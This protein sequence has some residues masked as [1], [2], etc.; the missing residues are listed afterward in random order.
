MAESGRGSW[1]EKF[2]K[3]QNTEPFG[4]E[5]CPRYT[6]EVDQCAALE[7]RDISSA[8]E[9]GLCLA[10]LKH[11][12]DE[13]VEKIAKGNPSLYTQED[14]TEDIDFDK[15]LTRMQRVDLERWDIR[16][17]LACMGT[18]VHRAV[19]LKLIRRGIIAEA[20][21][22]GSCKH[23]SQY[24]PRMCSLPRYVDPDSGGLIMNALHGEIRKLGDDP[25]PGYEDRQPRKDDCQDAEILRDT[26]SLNSGDAN[27]RRFATN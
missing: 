2:C 9:K 22:C 12:V 3:G 14:E 27:I 16:S 23:I 19:L 21:T 15:L 4:G 7:E 26:Q 5:P 25:C 6:V 11:I 8:F 20:K 24:M 10:L 17:W 18:A 13:K 1:I